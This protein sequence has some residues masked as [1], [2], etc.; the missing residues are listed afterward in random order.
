M[1]ITILPEIV[2]KEGITYRAIEPTSGRPAIW[3]AA[4]QV[5]SRPSYPSALTR[6]LSH[7]V[8]KIIQLPH[9]GRI[10]IW[11]HQTG[12]SLCLALCKIVR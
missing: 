7:R 11:D 5:S 4:V 1:T 3:P 6:L 9:L 12:R 8:F 10:K 2:G